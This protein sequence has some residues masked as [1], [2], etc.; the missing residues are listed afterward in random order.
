MEN[1]NF[2]ETQTQLGNDG[3]LRPHQARFNNRDLCIMSYFNTCSLL[4]KKQLEI[5]YIW[6]AM[7]WRP[8][9]QLTYEKWTI[10]NQTSL[11]QSKRKTKTF[12]LPVISIN[13]ES[14][15]LLIFCIKK[16]NQYLNRC[17][18]LLLNRLVTFEAA[19]R[20]LSLWITILVRIGAR[21]TSAVFSRR[22]IAADKTK[23]FILL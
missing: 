16:K 8:W 20:K 4:L 12:L 18:L 3:V 17:G 21:W 14:W 7:M 2:R 1:D 15:E 10:S 19:E 5:V 9:A 6:T 22:R 11:K 13:S 23:C